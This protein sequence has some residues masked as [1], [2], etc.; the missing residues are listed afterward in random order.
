MPTKIRSNNMTAF[1]KQKGW[2]KSKTVWVGLIGAVYASLALIGIPVP[3]GI[4]ES[5]ASEL[6]TGI[7]GLLAI[8]FRVTATEAISAEVLPKTEA[9]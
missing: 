6:V 2:W 9:L 3:F 1:Y 8:Y 7:V 4:D 5:T